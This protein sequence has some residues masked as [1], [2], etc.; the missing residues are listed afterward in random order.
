MTTLNPGEANLVRLEST[1][2]DLANI[3]ELTVL[4]TPLAPP[5]VM[6]T[7]SNVALGAGGLIMSGHGGMPF[8]TYQ[9]LSSTNLTTPLAGWTRLATNYFDG[10][11]NFTCTNTVIT[12]QPQQF[13]RL[14]VP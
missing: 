8:I 2:N 10:S 3:D 9:V 12:G 1:G 11:G 6:P 14:Q 7:V 5:V 13:F 4:G